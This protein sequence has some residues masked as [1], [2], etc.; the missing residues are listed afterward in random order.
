MGTHH[1]PFLYNIDQNQGFLHS[2]DI[3]PNELA[4]ILKQNFLPLRYPNDN[5]HANPFCPVCLRFVAPTQPFLGYFSN[6]FGKTFLA[7]DDC[8]R[9]EDNNC[10]NTIVEEINHAKLS[11]IG[12]INDARSF[13][14]GEK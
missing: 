11:F 4:T 3:Y 6:I 10:L 14:F 8:L 13:C 12:S 5:A 2:C 1:S 7:H 9:R